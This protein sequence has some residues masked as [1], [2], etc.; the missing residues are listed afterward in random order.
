MKLSVFFIV[1]EICCDSDARL[2]QND[3]GLAHL[4]AEFGR[5]GAFTVWRF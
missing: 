4:L 1:G 5:S 3:G 2:A